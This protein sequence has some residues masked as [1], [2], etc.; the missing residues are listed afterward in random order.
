M[1]PSLAFLRAAARTRLLLLPIIVAGAIIAPRA[2]AQTCQIPLG[3]PL[4]GISAV[5]DP[6]YEDFLFPQP[7]GWIG[8][9]NAHTIRLSDTKVLWLFSDTLIGTVSG[10]T[11]SLTSFLNN[12]IAIQDTSASTPGSIQFHWNTSGG[13]NS[14]FFPHQPGTPGTYYWPNAGVML[15][16]E[17]FIIC[18]SLD[19]G[20]GDFPFVM[21]GFTLIRIPNPQDSPDLWIQNAFDLGI[22]PTLGGQE[23]TAN[24]ALFVEEP[25]VYIFLLR[26]PGGFGTQHLGRVLIADLLAGE[27]GDSFEYWT[28]GTGGN[29]WRSTMD[30]LITLFTGGVTE[31]EIHYEERIGLYICFTYD[32]F[33]PNI[34]IRTAPALTGPWSAEACIFQAPEFQI[35]PSNIIIYAV[36]SHAELS[37]GYGELLVSYNT[38]WIGPSG[39]SNLFTAQGLE[40]Y[41]P[42][43][44]RLSYQLPFSS[45]LHWTAYE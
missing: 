5:V 8:G 4:E 19:P 26:G 31:T 44:I 28:S 9:D 13:G 7:V 41:Y 37:T 21:A 40:I 32:V 33:N 20:S 22:S 27:L 11:R 2:L 3:Y 43:F 14:S 35:D 15:D 39:F 12:S 6:D 17:L 18:T 38:N 30:N 23:L 10:G 34:T 16:G 24:A 42:R 25:Y 29:A 45:A 1:L 36:R